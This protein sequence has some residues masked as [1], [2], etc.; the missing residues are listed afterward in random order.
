LAA[1]APVVS[2]PLPRK[3]PEGTDAKERIVPVSIRGIAVL[4]RQLADL[5]QIRGIAVLKR[6]LADLHLER[7]VRPRVIF[8]GRKFRSILCCERANEGDKA[9]RSR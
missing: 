3:Q 7:T 2:K 6:Q 8:A 9:N 5:R 4:K 1:S